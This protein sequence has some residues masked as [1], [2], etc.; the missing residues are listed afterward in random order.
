MRKLWVFLC[1]VLAVVVFTAGS[2]FSLINPGKAR[3]LNR[4]NFAV[5]STFSSHQASWFIFP[6]WSS[7]DSPMWVSAR[8]GMAATISVTVTGAPVEVRLVLEDEK[9]QGPIMSMQ[10]SFAAF[11]PGTGTVSGSFTFVARINPDPYRV[12]LEMRSPTGADFTLVNGSMV[13][14]YAAA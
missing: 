12:I 10:P 7:S 11:D 2:S 5:L 13:V 14:Q 9:H 8:S 6:G 4:Q 3:P 1:V